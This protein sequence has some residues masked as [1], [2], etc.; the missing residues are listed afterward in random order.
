MKTFQS[1]V[2]QRGD[3]AFPAFTGERV[4][5]RQFRKADGLPFDLARWQPTVDA[6]LDGV[7]AD[8]PLYIMIDQGVV[9]AGVSHRRPGVHIDGYWN[10]AVRAH[11]GTGSHIGKSAHGGGRH[12][13]GADS[14][15]NADYVEHEG[16]LLASS[17]QA[18]RAFEGEFTGQPGVGGD[19][20]HIDLSGLREIPMLAGRTYAGNV[21]MLHDSLPVPFDCQRTLVRI[22]VPGWSV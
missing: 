10:P 8:G 20:A 6:M 12:L 21:T 3:V 2:Q 16:L 17:V 22:N 5:M 13:S 9:R 1:V 11:G 14:W 19:C 4:Y 18:A 15:A 7:D